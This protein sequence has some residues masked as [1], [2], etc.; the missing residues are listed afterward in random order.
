MAFLTKQHLSRR[1]FLNGMGVSLALPLLESMLPAATALAQTAARARTRLACIY[2]PHGATMDK[3]TPATD[4]SG[5][6]LSAQVREQFPFGDRERGRAAGFAQRLHELK[7][8]KTADVVEVQRFAARTVSGDV[9]LCPVGRPFEVIERLRV[10]EAGRQRRPRR[11]RARQLG[12]A[13]LE[14]IAPFRLG[15]EAKRNCRQPLT[16][17]AADPR[18][19]SNADPRS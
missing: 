4:G 18:G 7:M 1:T 15:I 13:Q 10:R 2:V 9:P 19:A 12:G 3:W 16:L 17:G 11:E 8:R 6:E 5:F 14:I